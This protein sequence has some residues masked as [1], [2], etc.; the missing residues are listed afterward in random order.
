MAVFNVKD[1]VTYLTNAERV[2]LTVANL[3]DTSKYWDLDLK[4]L[5]IVYNGAWYA[6]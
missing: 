6:M 4:A 3:P 1:D 2:A 5:Y